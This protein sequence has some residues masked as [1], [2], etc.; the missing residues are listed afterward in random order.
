MKTLKPHSCGVVLPLLFVSLNSAFLAQA[1]VLNGDFSAGNSG[2]TSAYSFIS[3]G[4]STTPGTY[5]VRTNS[6]DFNPGY[7][8]F[9]DHTTGSGNMMLV[10]GATA[11]GT[12]VWQQTL[13]VT[14]NTT[15]KFSAWATPANSSNPSILQFSINGIQVGSSLVLSNT[16]GQWRRFSAFWNSGSSVAATLT[17]RDNNGISLG[18]DFALDDFSFTLSTNTAVVVSIYT[19]VEIG[20]NSELNQTYQV[21]YA[22]TLAPNTWLDLGSPV[23]GNGATNYIFDSTRGQPAKFYRVLTE[24]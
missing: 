19:A 13:P 18:N 21:Q 23:Q 16:P 6:L 2:F 14:T 1:D 8:L 17:V 3:S 7:N 4:T 24:P 15:Y 20:W 5:G 10:D 12:I 9:G 22:T 11:T